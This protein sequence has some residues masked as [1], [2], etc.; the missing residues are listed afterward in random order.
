MVVI[1]VD[2]LDA[3]CDGSGFED[4]LSCSLAVAVGKDC[5]LTGLVT[6]M[7]GGSSWSRSGEGSVMVIG[8]A[9]GRFEVIFIQLK[10]WYVLIIIGDISWHGRS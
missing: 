6:T 8:G 7:D 10:H 3:G 4:D 9:S 5:S 2:V 1:G